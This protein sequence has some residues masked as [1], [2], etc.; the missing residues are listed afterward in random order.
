MDHRLRRRRKVLSGD[1]AVVD[2]VDRPHMVGSPD[3]PQV[4][5]RPTGDEGSIPNL[6]YSPSL[7]VLTGRQDRH[8]STAAPWPWTRSVGREGVLRPDL[9]D[10]AT[11]WAVYNDRVYRGMRVLFAHSEVAKNRQEAAVAEIAAVAVLQSA[12]GAAWV[13]EKSPAPTAGRSSALGRGI[14]GVTP[15]QVGLGMGCVT[16]RGQPDLRRLLRR[17]TT[18]V[19]FGADL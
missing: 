9:P 1:L 16:A 15:C 12:F 14:F 18:R 8:A 3:P 17:R 13:K 11:A 7:C 2:A 10:D 4:L 19:L 6:R 5:R